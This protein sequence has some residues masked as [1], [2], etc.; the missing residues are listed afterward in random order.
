MSNQSEFFKTLWNYVSQLV[1]LSEWSLGREVRRESLS[2]SRELKQKLFSSPHV[3]RE[4]EKNLFSLYRKCVIFLFFINKQ[5]FFSHVKKKI[6]KNLFSFFML[7]KK[8]K[9]FLFFP[10]V[11]RKERWDF[12]SLLISQRSLCRFF[13]NRH[14]L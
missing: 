10:H 6:E 11:I 1:R 3:K 13:A 4:I 14:I 7:K 8:L 9:K 2:F 12:I 5:S